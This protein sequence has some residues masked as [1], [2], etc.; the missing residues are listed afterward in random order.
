MAEEQQAHPGGLRRG[1][2]GQD[3]LP[4]RHRQ[5]L[6]QRRDAHHCRS[7]RGPLQC[8]SAVIFKGTL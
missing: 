2:H 8:E 5:Q 3:A 7:F 4:L 1:G 6:L